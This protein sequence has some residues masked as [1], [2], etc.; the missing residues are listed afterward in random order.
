MG[1]L[2]E[3]PSWDGKASEGEAVKRV[4]NRGMKHAGVLPMGEAVHIFSHVEW[5][6]TGFHILLQEETG[7]PEDIFFVTK[8]ELA[9]RYMLP[10]AFHYYLKQII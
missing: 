4:E 9:E 3:F 5:H 2:Y 10:V 8:E 7:V 6:M 1:G